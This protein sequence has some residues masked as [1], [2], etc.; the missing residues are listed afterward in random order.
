MNEGR[1]AR[2]KPIQ[3]KATKVTKGM[4]NR[5]GKEF[6]RRQR[7]ERREGT[8]KLQTSNLKLQGRFKSQ[9]PTEESLQGFAPE[10]MAW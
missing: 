2:R 9:T 10:R 3:Q 8:E 7:R 6:Y 4:K 5:M 1:P